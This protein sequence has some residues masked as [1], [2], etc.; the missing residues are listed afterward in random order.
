M[1]ALLT[2]C[3]CPRWAGRLADHRPYPD[4]A[5]LQAAGDE[6]GY[7]LTPA[8]QTAA[9]AQEPPAPLPPA[10]PGPGT[11]AAHT[12]LRAAHAAYERRFRH[13]FVICL[14]G[15][16]DDELLDQTLHAIRT[17]L[18]HEPDEERSVA[19]EELRRLARARLGRLAVNCP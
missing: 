12:A 6:A 11:L 7:D 5:A 10:R 4:A 19:A 18:A 14:D 3:A 13:A 1:A 16:H 9:L 2:C 8:E 15:Y 17:R